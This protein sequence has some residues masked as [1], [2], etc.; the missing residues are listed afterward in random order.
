MAVDCFEQDHA[1]QLEAYRTGRL[2]GSL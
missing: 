2:R 1:S